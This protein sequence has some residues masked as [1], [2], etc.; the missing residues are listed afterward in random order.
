[1]RL[2]LDELSFQAEGGSALAEL[3][4]VELATPMT[5]WQD[6]WHDLFDLLLSCGVAVAEHPSAAV[7][8]GATLTAGALATSQVFTSGEH[9][10]LTAANLPEAAEAMAAVLRARLNDKRAGK[11]VLLRAE[12]SVELDGA[13]SR[14]GLPGSECRNRSTARPFVQVLPLYLRLH[15]LP[16]DPETLRQFLLLP[17]CPVEP[18]LRR[19]LL[20]ALK[21]EEFAPYGEDVKT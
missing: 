6:I 9:L 15:L 7:F 14:Y 11:I 20:S 16:F 19:K 18:D 1:M 8:R 21:Y 12:N 3:F 4:S 17:V 2:I 5:H 10:D 13:L